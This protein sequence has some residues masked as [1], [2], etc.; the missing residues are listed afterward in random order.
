MKII[1]SRLKSGHSESVIK[2]YSTYHNIKAQHIHKSSNNFP[3]EESIVSSSLVGVSGIQEYRL[4]SCSLGLLGLLVRHILDPCEAAVAVT[5]RAVVTGRDVLA[6]RQEVGVHV[7]RVQQ[8][9]VE[10]AEG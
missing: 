1:N 9:D 8:E 3:L 5:G 2:N 10:A 4:S 6:D 7:V